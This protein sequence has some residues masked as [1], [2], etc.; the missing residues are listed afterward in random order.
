MDIE[1]SHFLNDNAQSKNKKVQLHA[2]TSVEGERTIRE[3]YNFHAFLS[4]NVD[5]LLESLIKVGELF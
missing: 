1:S 5:V 3:F 4:V 2:C